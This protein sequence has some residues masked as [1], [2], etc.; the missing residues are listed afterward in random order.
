M[1]KP[2]I[3]SNAHSHKKTKVKSVSLL[4]IRYQPF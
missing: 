2:I 1:T 3:I 4:T